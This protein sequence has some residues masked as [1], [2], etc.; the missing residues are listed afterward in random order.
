MTAEYQ[1]GTADSIPPG[2]H[3]VVDVEGRQIGIFNVDGDF[4]A[5]PNVCFHQSG[6]LCRGRVGGTVIANAETN[7]KPEWRLEG[8]VVTCPWHSLEFNIKT[9]HC[10]AYPNRKVRTYPVRVQ[11]GILSVI[12]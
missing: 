2:Q 4:Y 10:L 1:I 3:R 7:H 12:C 8:E 9:G 6:P 5:L 11:D